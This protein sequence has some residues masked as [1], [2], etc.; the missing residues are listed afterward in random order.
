MGFILDLSETVTSSCSSVSKLKVTHLAHLFPG[1]SNGP[2]SRHIRIKR[3]LYWK[4]FHLKCSF[5]LECSHMCHCFLHIKG[6]A[7]IFLFMKHITMHFNNPSTKLLK[8]NQA[9]ASILFDYWH[10][11]WFW[12]MLATLSGLDE[13]QICLNSWWQKHKK[14]KSEVIFHHNCYLLKKF[15]PKAK[16]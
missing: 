3:P 14:D 2:S 5:W 1:V 13:E 12:N 9:P 4:C 15:F 6:G 10:M 7:L 11:Q 16:L 8:L